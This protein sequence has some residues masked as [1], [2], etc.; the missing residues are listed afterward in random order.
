M[1]TVPTA[2]LSTQDTT[3]AQPTV[4][5][6]VAGFDVVPFLRM[7]K[8][9]M[10]DLL[11]EQRLQQEEARE[12]GKSIP[13]TRTGQFA[14]YV[15]DT[16]ATQIPGKM[17]YESL[18][19]GTASIFEELA[20]FQGVAPKERG[21]TDD[22]ILQMLIRNPDGKPIERG[23][24][25]EGVKEEIAPQVGGFCWG[26]SWGYRWRGT[27]SGCASRNTTHYCRKVHGSCC[28]CHPWRFVWSRNCS[29][30]AK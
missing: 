23:S 1:A 4:T 27:R 12:Q 26:S 29:H 17:T 30:R 9:E 25:L 21:L 16:V 20:P 11:F 2:T 8:E 13:G 15:A 5:D 6:Q 28:R 18:K 19:D 14:K 22:Q 10:D 7:S 24:F 3:I